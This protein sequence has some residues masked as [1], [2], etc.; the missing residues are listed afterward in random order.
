MGRKQR[1]KVK[2]PEK[3][4]AALKQHILLEPCG[5]VADRPHCRPKDCPAQGSMSSRQAVAG[6]VMLTLLR[7]IDHLWGKCIHPGSPGPL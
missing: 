7:I 1:V 4:N 2:G 6:K 3:A 5:H